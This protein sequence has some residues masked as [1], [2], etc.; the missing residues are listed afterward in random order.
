MSHGA[1]LNHR[2]YMGAEVA[3]S[4]RLQ[5]AICSQVAPGS[6]FA[7]FT[8]WLSYSPC[9]CTEADL[10]CNFGFRRVLNVQGLATATTN[11]SCTWDSASGVSQTAL[12]TRTVPGDECQHGATIQPSSLPTARHPSVAPSRPTPSPSHAVGPP[13][14][15]GIPTTAS[16]I[17]THANTGRAGSSGSDGASPGAIAAVVVFALIGV[18]GGVWAHRT[19][20]CHIRKGPRYARVTASNTA[21]EMDEPDPPGTVDDD[22]SSGDDEDLLDA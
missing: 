1:S 12:A 11:E 17:A 13:T 4:R 14:P 22:A 6:A 18:V 21:F 8:D 15:H 10:A 7:N 9:P 20:R 5:C 16:P 3:I 19:G 2:S